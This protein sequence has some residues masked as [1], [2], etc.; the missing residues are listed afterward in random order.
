MSLSLAVLLASVLLAPPV[1][2]PVQGQPPTKAERDRTS[3]LMKAPKPGPGGFVGD[4]Y[5]LDICIV[6]NEPLGANAVTVIL[7]DM[8]DPLQEW[9]HMRF[10]CDTCVAKFRAEPAK[11]IA[12]LDK[13]IIE[14]FDRDFPLDRCIVMIEETLDDD[15]ERVV[16]AN[17][18]YRLCCRKCITN[19][20]KQT[21]R[22]TQAYERMLA[23]KQRSEYPL[24][25]CVVTGAPL[26]E[27]PFDL[28][29]G[30]RLVR[31]ADADAAKRFYE[32]P[33]RY[34]KAIDE[35]K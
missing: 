4:P 27:K 7:K 20:Q 12:A 19:F 35:A 28:V 25:T 17:R 16:Y 18:V 13:A 8:A 10:C 21:E 2:A 3:I 31:L 5:P 33:A 23:A 26:P 15:A 24:K 1:S 11:Y 6:G 9:R 32:D 30:A 29:I 34:L 14:R 22:Y